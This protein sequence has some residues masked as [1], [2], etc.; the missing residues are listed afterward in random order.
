M[1]V[2]GRRFLLNAPGVQSSAAIVAEIEDTRRWQTGRF[3]RGELL[4]VDDDT[5]WHLAPD[6]T[7]KL[8]DCTRSVTFEVGWD[9]ALARRSALQKVDLMIEALTEF[10]GALADEQRLY[11][12][13]LRLARLAGPKPKDEKPGAK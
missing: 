7:L 12:R 13:R 3:R 9:S 10:R 2:R 8:A 1:A 4:H 5:S 6:V 11:V